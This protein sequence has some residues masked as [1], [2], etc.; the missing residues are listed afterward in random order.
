MSGEARLPARPW[1]SMD[2]ARPVPASYTTMQ[3]K[4]PTPAENGVVM[5]WAKAVATA[6]STA[7]PP[8][9][10]APTP[11]STA[12]G[13]R[14]TTIPPPA[15]VAPASGVPAAVS[16]PSDPHAASEPEAT[17]PHPGRRGRD[18]GPP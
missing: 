18:E 10:S 3:P 4:P 14:A 8:R 5:N 2:V 11:A 6:A 12:M 7:L 17:A 1:K 16:P 9:L 15:S 13:P